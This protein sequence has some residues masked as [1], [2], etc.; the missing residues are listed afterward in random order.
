MSKHRSRRL[1]ALTGLIPLLALALAV[2]TLSAVPLRAAQE[3]LAEV[4]RL[5]YEGQKV[6]AFLLLKELAPKG[7]PEAQYKLAG[8]YHYGY[9]GPA[10]YQ[11]ALEWYERAARQGHTDAMLGVAI[12][13][14]QDKISIPQNKARAFTWLSI[15]ATQLKD[16][17][18]QANVATL[19][20]KLKSEISTAELQAALNEAMSFQPVPETQ[21]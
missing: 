14:A 17:D 21:Q 4:S 5:E 2:I 13:N 19:R 9:A 20:D 18:A 8:Y 1:G 10:N 16:A 3:D 12:L 15:A 7:D 6:D 11:L